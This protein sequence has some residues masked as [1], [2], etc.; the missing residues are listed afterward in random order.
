MQLLIAAVAKQ[1]A[2]MIAGRTRGYSS[3]WGYQNLR[4]SLEFGSGKQD[5]DE[6]D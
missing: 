6:L 4:N 1:I 5:I 3:V 2:M